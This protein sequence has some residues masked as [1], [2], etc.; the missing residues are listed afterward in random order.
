MRPVLAKATGRKLPFCMVRQTGQAPGGDVRCWAVERGERF[1]SAV[2]N[3]N[4]AAAGCMS[5]AGRTQACG[6]GLAKPPTKKLDQVA[7]FMFW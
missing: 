1:G 3:H 4:A 7:V 5:A 2:F 6:M